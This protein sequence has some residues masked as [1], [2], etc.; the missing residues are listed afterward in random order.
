MQALDN[1]TPKSKNPSA[2][3]LGSEFGGG[4]GQNRL[5]D[6]ID[7]P[8]SQDSID[9]VMIAHVDGND[10]MIRDDQLK[11]NPIFQIDRHT[12]Q[13]FQLALQAMKS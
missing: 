6:R 13:T 5:G 10:F 7:H 11:G 2:F 8:I 4:P 12:V 3:K 1:R 9:F